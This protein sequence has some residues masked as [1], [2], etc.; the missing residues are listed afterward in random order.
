MRSRRSRWWLLL[1]T[2]LILPEMIPMMISIS[3]IPLRTLL[4]SHRLSEI[5]RLINIGA[6]NNR[7]MVGQKLQHN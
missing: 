6:F 7:D 3:G 1:V 2:W 5:S 4:N